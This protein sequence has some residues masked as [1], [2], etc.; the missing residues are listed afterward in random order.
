MEEEADI[1]AVRRDRVLVT[2]A[3]HGDARPCL[4]GLSDADGHA[5]PGTIVTR[6]E[7]PKGFP[8]A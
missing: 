2:A 5:V 3:P 7:T 8:P 4:T 1:T 6:A